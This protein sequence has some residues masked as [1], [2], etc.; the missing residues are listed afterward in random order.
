[1]YIATVSR[2]DI[3]HIVN[4][5]SRSQRRF[6]NNFDMSHV[7]WVKRVL[8]YLLKTS[9][10]GISY[11]NNADELCPVAHTAA[12]FANCLDTR[13]STSGCIILYANVP[14]V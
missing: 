1:M 6:V 14:V 12:D 4:V 8:K 13:K 3:P 11:K 7:N 2:P 9:N 10:T 5:L